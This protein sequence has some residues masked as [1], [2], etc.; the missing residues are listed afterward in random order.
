[1]KLAIQLPTEKITEFCQRWQIQEFALFGSILRS[2]FSADSDIDVMVNF[3]PNTCWSLL[4]RVRMEQELSKILGRAVDLIE[5]DEIIASPNWIRR[6]EILNSA[7][8]FYVK[9]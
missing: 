6:R 3:E 8:I 4:D 1:M 9:R 7:Q 5:R 2:D